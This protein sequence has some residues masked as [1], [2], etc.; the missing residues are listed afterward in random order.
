MDSKKESNRRWKTNRKNEN[1][2]L[3]GSFE[4]ANIWMPNV[5]KWNVEQ[6]SKHNWNI[7]YQQAI[8]TQMN[9]DILKYYLRYNRSE[10]ADSDEIS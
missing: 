5:E 7:N 3:K 2:I 4:K 1:D 9:D 6:I 8:P 10:V